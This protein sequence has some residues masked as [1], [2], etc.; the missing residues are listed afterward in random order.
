M[1]NMCQSLILELQGESSNV[2][3]TYVFTLLD[4]HGTLPAIATKE[5]SHT[6][7]SH[8]DDWGYSKFYPRTILKQT[9]VKDCYFVLR[10]KITVK[11]ESCTRANCNASSIGFLRE[12]IQK[13]RE[14]KRCTDVSFDVNGEIFVLID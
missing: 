2:K 4:K 13:L 12:H 1:A 6:V 3:T 11:D 7:T 8:E 14:E 10:V 9:Y 5:T